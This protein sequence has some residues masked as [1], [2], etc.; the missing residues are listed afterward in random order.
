AEASAEAIRRV[1]ASIGTE[2]APM[3]YLLGERYISS[4]KDLAASQNAKFVLFPADLQAT[5]GGLLGKV[6]PRQ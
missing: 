6:L 1:T 4:V 5:I 3:L 2:Q